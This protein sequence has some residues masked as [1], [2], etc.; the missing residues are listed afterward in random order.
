[1]PGPW[2]VPEE[3]LPSAEIL[4]HPRRAGGGLSTFLLRLAVRTT[5]APASGCL[6]DDVS[7]DVH[8]ALLPIFDPATTRFQQK[9]PITHGDLH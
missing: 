7:L 8:L 4:F 5:V 3:N 1:M 9:H 2:L 6:V